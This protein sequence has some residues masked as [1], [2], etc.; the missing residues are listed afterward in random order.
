MSLEWYHKLFIAQVDVMEE[1]GITVEDQGLVNAIAE[2]A[3][4]GNAPIA[5][6]RNQA[7]QHSLVIRFIRGTNKQHAEYLTHLRNSFL[8]GQNFYLATVEEAFSILQQCERNMPH[9]NCENNG[10]SFVNAGIDEQ[11]KKNSDEPPKQQVTCFNCGKQGHFANKCPHQKI[12]AKGTNLC[13]DTDNKSTKNVEDDKDDAGFMFSQAESIPKSWIL[14][15]SQSTVDLFCNDSLLKNI[16]RVD[17]VMKV[18]CNAGTRSINLIGDLQAYGWV[19]YDPSAIANILSLKNV[20][21]KFDVMYHVDDAANAMF[22]VTKADGSTVKF[23]KSKTGL[24]YHETSIKELALLVNTVADN[25]F[26]YSNRDYLRAL[27]AR[28]LQIKI[29]RP[30]KKEFINII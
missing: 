10:M 3:G 22:I 25:K 24:Y 23:I 20:H 26:K 14:L 1:V 2:A 4:R 19:W 12:E 6:D 8:D 21:T 17:T 5:A 27:E 13:M 29:G 30:S 9:I 18:K 15:D 7:R 28:E 11:G 16:Q